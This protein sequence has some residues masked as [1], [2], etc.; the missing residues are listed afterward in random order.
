MADTR[1]PE[2]RRKIMQSVR[3]K[4]TGTEL[5]VR[6]LLFS[7]GYRY[8]LHRDG[9]P[10]RPDIVFP[11]RKKAVLVHGC[12]WHG[13]ECRKGASPKSRNHYW[14]PKIDANRA[15]DDGDLRRLKESGWA[16][17]VVWQCELNDR[18]ALAAK[19]KSF[20]DN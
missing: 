7:M 16:V 18:D 8:R 1:T 12:F 6:R 13:H 15:R 9:L 11:G 4:N 20:V 3:S 19:L 10:G 17:I 14:G 5:Q 2:Q